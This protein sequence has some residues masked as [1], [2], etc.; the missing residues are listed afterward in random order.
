VSRAAATAD[1]AIVGGGILGCSI[2]WHLKRRRPE[3]RIVVLEREGALATQ[4]TSKAAA[5]LTHARSNAA[6]LRGAT[7]RLGVGVESVVA[8][9]GRV[10][11]LVT[12]VGTAHARWSYSPPA[13]GR[14]FSQ[15]RSV[16][17]LR[18]RRYAASTG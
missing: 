1:V 9:G 17:A 10:E 16:A 5:L 7:F 3:A 8:A 13:P 2:A 11:G 14:T 15:P 6:R 12:S 4:A 18:W